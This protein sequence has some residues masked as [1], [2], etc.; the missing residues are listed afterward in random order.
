MRKH[1]PRGTSAGI[2]LYR[3][4]AQ[5]LNADGSIPFVFV[6]RKVSE[7]ALLDSVDIGAELYRVTLIVDTPP[8]LNQAYFLSKD[9][10]VT[11]LPVRVIKRETGVMG[12]YFVM[13]F[14]CEL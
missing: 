1:L 9:G 13:F 7:L 3:D 14:Q 2:L 8:D 5:V 10:G 6:E 4:N 12:C 11:K